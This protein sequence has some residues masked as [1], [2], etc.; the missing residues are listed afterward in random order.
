MSCKETKVLIDSYMSWFK[1]EIKLEEIEGACEITTPFLD[2]HNDYIVIY[3]EQTDG[4]FLLTDDGETL[5]DLSLSGVEITPLRNQI[6]K[7]MLNGFGVK[8]EN[9]ELVVTGE[10]K[11]FPKR[12]HNLVQAILAVNDMFML[13]RTTVRG[14]FLETVQAY[15]KKQEVH[16]AS[17]IPLKGKSGLDHTFD[18]HIAPTV[19]KPEYLIQAIG[20]PERQTIIGRVLFPYEDLKGTRT[21]SVVIIAFLNDEKRVSSDLK[22]SIRNVGCEPVLWSE[23]EKILPKL[24][25]VTN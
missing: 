4:G 21:T 6:L 12:K 10:P 19:D 5:A 17:R 15:L 14:L 7:V 9:D 13:S 18:F 11:N 25:K 2:R 16:F 3:L 8:R 23:R 1:E 24:A 20:S 22:A